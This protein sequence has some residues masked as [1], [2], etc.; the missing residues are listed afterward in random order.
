M[1]PS[2]ACPISENGQVADINRWRV[3]AVVDGSP[4]VEAKCCR[5]RSKI[6]VPRAVTGKSL[7]ATGFDG[8]LIVVKATQ[9]SEWLGVWGTVVLRPGWRVTRGV[10]GGATVVAV[11]TGR[12]TLSAGT[13]TRTA[14]RTFAVHLAEGGD[15]LLHL[16]LVELAI[17]VGIELEGM[18]QHPLGIRSH[19]RSARSAAT[20]TTSLTLSATGAT[21]TTGAAA[22]SLSAGASTGAA[23]SPTLSARTWLTA[24]GGPPGPP[25][26][27]W[28]SSSVTLPSL[29]LSSFARAAA[30]FFNSS[31]EIT[32]S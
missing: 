30:A 25:R 23:R 20:G 24:A 8:R 22:L 2:K 17:V 13:G 26:C 10:S 15:E 19:P 32:P 6:I 5:A 1:S 29:F 9:P 21:L 11:V 27:G 3:L 4:Y 31:A 7:P 16:V 12:A 14:G 28:S 18:G